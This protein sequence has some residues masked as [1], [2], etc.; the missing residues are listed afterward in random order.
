[1]YRDLRDI[2]DIF[3]DLHSMTR[4]MGEELGK[5]TSTLQHA[6]NVSLIVI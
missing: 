4:S 2:K 1:M 3:T 5:R 6:F